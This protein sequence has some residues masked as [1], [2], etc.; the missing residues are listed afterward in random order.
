M[1]SFI[2]LLAIIISSSLFVITTSAYAADNT[3]KKPVLSPWQPAVYD[4]VGEAYGPKQK[5]RAYKTYR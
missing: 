4:W 2:K 5:K 3:L 1:K